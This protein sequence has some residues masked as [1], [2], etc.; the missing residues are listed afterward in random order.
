MGFAISAIFAIGAWLLLF[1][2]ETDPDRLFRKAGEDLA[3][4]RFD[5]VSADIIRLSKLRPPTS[6]DRLLRAELYRLTGRDAEA[7][8]ELSEIPDQF[9]NASAVRFAQ[10]LL[11]LRLN[12]ARQAEAA[13]RRA[14]ELNPKKNDARRELIR[15]ASIQDR[16]DVVSAQFISLSRQ[17]EVSLEFDDLYLWTL[18]RSRSMGP[19]ES[20]EILERWVAADPDDR[21]SRVGL[22]SAFRKLGKLDES[23]AILS[24]L[25]QGVDELSPGER[26]LAVRVAIDQVDLEKAH[27]LLDSAKSGDAEI[28]L[29]RGRLFLA[30]S[31]PK[32][33]LE[34]LK[35]S[36]LTRPNNR[37]ALTTLSITL[38]LLRK[39]TEAEAILTKVQ[40]GNDME[41]LIQLA[42][43]PDQQ[44]SVQTL[45]DIA[46]ACEKLGQREQA[47][48]W[49]RLALKEDPTNATLQA[50]LFR[51][52]P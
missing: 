4:K 51:L 37:E 10:G 20:A 26:A 1:G 13:F 25:S 41:R 14:L 28:E 5:Q 18:G 50:A 30:K 45:G 39:Q 11:E 15:I 27:R 24:A 38:R 35:A 8:R 2:P 44:R 6:E 9:A 49:Y 34:C 32:E 40:L 3:S 21:S 7:S 33:A 12:R 46:T 47:R 42:Q 16:L 17:S 22:T 48:A 36:I 52:A 19:A 29:L 31:R 43:V 23:E